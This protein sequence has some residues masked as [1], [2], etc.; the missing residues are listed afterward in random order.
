MLDTNFYYNLKFS[1]PTHHVS[2]IDLTLT[3]IVHLNVLH[4]Q[5]TLSHFTII[6]ILF[7]N[8]RAVS[9]ALNLPLLQTDMLVFNLD[10][11]PDLY[12]IG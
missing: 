7:L 4:K 6:F 5:I 1:H 8:K 3:R 12:L 9:T 2:S 11:R 10:F